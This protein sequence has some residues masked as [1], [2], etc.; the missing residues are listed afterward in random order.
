ME[1]EYVNP[2]SAA[3]DAIAFA[4]KYYN[5]LGFQ[6][7]FRNFNNSAGRRFLYSKYNPS[8]YIGQDGEIIG[9][10]KKYNWGVTKNP[11]KFNK[12]HP[13]LGANAYYDPNTGNISYGNDAALTQETG[14]DTWDKIM[15]HEVGHAVDFA[16]KPK[17]F[18]EDGD[19]LEYYNKGYG[20]TYSNMYPIFRNSKSY[21]AIKNE[22]DQLDAAHGKLYEKDPS[23]GS[24][25]ITNGKLFHDAMP[26]ES[27]ADLFQMR[28]M[29][30]DQKIFDSTKAG[31]KF[32]KQHL[33]KFKQNNHTRLQDNFSD[34]DIIWMIN[35]VANS[36]NKRKLN[37]KQ[38]EV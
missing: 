14:F 18:S 23:Y 36:G 37:P 10:G 8:S 24:H 19:K 20:Y 5:S 27:Y 21:Q 9:H 28:K 29:L 25:L 33:D 22:L 16:I 12:I 26:S 3:Q 38:K 4:N 17:R 6:Q 13:T 7:R 1:P 2:I 32:T 35:N 31:I 34:N 15:A 30:Y 11:L